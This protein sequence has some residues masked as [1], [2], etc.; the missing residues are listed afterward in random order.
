M[1][2]ILVTSIILSC[3]LLSACNDSTSVGIIGGADGPTAIVVG[4][5]DEIVSD[6]KWGLSLYAE[7]VTPKGIT[8]KIEQ[9]GGSPT[10]E[11]QTGEWFSLEV[12]KDNEWKAVETNPLV[13]YAW[14]DVAYLIKKNDITE[15]KVD[16]KWLYGELEPGYYRL[17][18]E[19]M[20]FRETGDFD[21]EIYEVYFTIE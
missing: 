9:F 15:L 19:I 1:K 16:W 7:D 6:D 2:R 14:N 17:K 20:D 4:K 21:K 18:K 3:L 12:I 11:L 5:N 8:L 13:D 10:G